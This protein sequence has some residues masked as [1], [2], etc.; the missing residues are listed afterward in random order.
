MNA[1]V[2]TAEAREIALAGMGASRLR[3]EDA[4]FIQGKGNYVDDIKLPGC[5]ATIGWAYYDDGY[6]AGQLAIKVLRG[7]SPAKLAF[8]RLTKTELLVNRT[9]A[10]SLGLEIPE[11]V[12]KEAKE[13]VS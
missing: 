13:V 2:Q 8:E 5:L 3:K 4:R 9:T 1:P 11:A 12:L 10:A 6:A 7:E